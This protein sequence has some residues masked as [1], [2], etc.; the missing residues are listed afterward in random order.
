M[1][2]AYQEQEGPND[3]PYNPWFPA[4]KTGLAICLYVVVLSVLVLWSI[5]TFSKKL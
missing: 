3:M 5:E 4:T 1:V 2:R